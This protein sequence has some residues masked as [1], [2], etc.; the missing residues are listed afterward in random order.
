MQRRLAAPIAAVVMAPAGLFW[1]SALALTAGAKLDLTDT[2]LGPM[3]SRWWPALAPHA[4]SISPAGAALMVVVFGGPL[5][6]LLLLAASMVKANASVEAGRVQL[7][8]QTRWLD[9]VDAVQLAVLTALGVCSGLWLIP[10]AF[11]GS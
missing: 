1:A 8:I 11:L 10:H 6:A 5:L 3:L 7:N 2:R 9:G 4:G